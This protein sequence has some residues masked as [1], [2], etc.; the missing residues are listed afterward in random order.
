M[1]LT[2]VWA[3]AELGTAPGKKKVDV[4]T[5]DWSRALWVDVINLSP[6]LLEIQGADAQ[7]IGVAMPFSRSVQELRVRQPFVLLQP[8]G[9]PVQTTAD[10]PASS[11]MV[12]V[13]V[14]QVR[15]AIGAL[16]TGA[17]AGGAQSVPN[18]AGQ[19][20]NIQV[21]AAATPLVSAAPVSP[22]GARK[23]L[24]IWNP[25]GGVT[26][27]IGYAAGVTAG[28]P[29]AGGAQGV[30]LVAGTNLSFG[31]GPGIALWGITA[32][33]NQVVQLEEVA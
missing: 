28:A 9:T 26:V 14:T 2:K 19:I 27:Y 7:A 5:N 4:G 20:N 23:S 8:V 17:A 22:L 33:G 25:S 21:G 31:I 24:R 1:S 29:A 32:A 6:Y 18:T 30:P 10:W 16:L 15:P 11:W 13:D 3:A 12:Y